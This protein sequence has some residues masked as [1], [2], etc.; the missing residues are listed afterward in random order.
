M[1]NEE[2][3]FCKTPAKD[4]ECN[5]F[6]F[7]AQLKLANNTS[8]PRFAFP[9]TLSPPSILAFVQSYSSVSILVPVAQY[10]DLP[11]LW[12]KAL[13]LNEELE[14]LSVQSPKKSNK[15]ERKYAAP[16]E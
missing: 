2:M 12:P 14:C 4:G 9:L 6:F 3:I 13:Y 11:S 15:M 7:L 16:S 10:P 1:Q 8:T 5:S